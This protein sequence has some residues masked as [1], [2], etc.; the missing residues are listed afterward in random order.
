MRAAPL[1][2]LAACGRLHFE[3]E[4]DADAMS[5]DAACVLGAFSPPEKVGGGVSVAGADDWSPA[6]TA[7]ELTMYFYSF[8]GGG[9]GQSDLYV[10][11]RGL[12]SDPFGPA[13]LLPVSSTVGDTGPRP[14]DDELALFL[15]TERGGSND[16]YV[17]TRMNRGTPFETAVPVPELNSGSDEDALAISP[18]GLRI[19]FASARDGGQDLFRAERLDRNLPFSNV[20]PVTELNSSSEDTTPTFSRDELEVFFVSNRPGGQGLRDIWRATRS[21]RTDPF[22]SLENVTALSSDSDE[23]GPFLSADSTRLYYTYQTPIIG[24]GDQADVWMATR[25]CL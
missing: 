22:G 12:R 14:T 10:A 18:D 9:T 17:S 21:S 13:T 11:T 24:S 4:V 3:V 20:V 1:L 25:S 16:I 8:R 2:L 19:M 15:L 6:V 5:L 23:W 7:D